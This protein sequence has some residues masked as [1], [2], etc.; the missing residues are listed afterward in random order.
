MGD[1]ADKWAHCLAQ[2]SIPDHIT[3]AAPRSPWGFPVEVFAAR[4]EESLRQP[5]SPTSE[6]ARA[7]LSGGQRPTLLDV[8]CG[9]GYA[10][11]PLVPP[12]AQLTGV[13]SSADMLTAFS[14]R[15][16]ELGAEVRTVEGRWP[17]V[18]ESVAPHDVVVCSDVVFGVAGIEEFLL[19]L[20]AK[21]K[22]LVVLELSVEHPLAWMSPL[23]ETFHG[24]KRPVEPV[25]DDLLDVLV[26]LALP[27]LE[28]IRWDRAERDRAQWSERVA[29]VTTRLCLPSS[30]EP[31]V[32]QA[33][34]AVV[35]ATRPVAT[36][37]WRGNVAR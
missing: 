25:L 10:S 12:A 27:G 16:R 18:S 32:A 28:V 34:S 23:W 2:W 13:D 36:V 21:A 24:L 29:R 9:A 31:E 30:R 20:T 8:G 3:A 6:R 35:T 7:A 19:A 15:G 1:A 22:T 4:A 17:D 33:L 11:L 14:K 5:D 26:H 37:S